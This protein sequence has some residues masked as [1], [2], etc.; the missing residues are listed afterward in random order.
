[1]QIRIRK[2]STQRRK[3]ISVSSTSGI[4]QELIRAKSEMHLA[5]K[6]KA[7]RCLIS[8]A[9]RKAKANHIPSNRVLP[10]HDKSSA[11]SISTPTAI[12]HTTDA[13]IGRSIRKRLR[14]NIT[15]TI[16]TTTM[17]TRKG[18][19][20]G[21]GGGGG[22]RRGGGGGKDVGDDEERTISEMISV[23]KK[24][25]WPKGPAGG[26]RKFEPVSRPAT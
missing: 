17:T 15:T 7:G 13:N 5:V 3:E 23:L 10:V 18:G 26:R 11:R 21:E 4:S 25:A 14:S 22:G 20:G 19:R 24:I 6:V 9:A 1:L 8:A 16:R 2:T 12:A